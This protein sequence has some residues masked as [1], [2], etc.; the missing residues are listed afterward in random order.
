MSISQNAPPPGA[1]SP[2]Y[3]SPTAMKQLVDANEAT[4]MD[5]GRLAEKMED[6]ERARAAYEAALKNNHDSIPAKKAIAILHKDRFK[7]TE[8]VDIANTWH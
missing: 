2:N 7:S 5:I 1:A 8:K 4:W 3:P 6:Y